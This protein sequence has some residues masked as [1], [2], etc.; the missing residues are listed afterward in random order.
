M[1]KLIHTLLFISFIGCMQAQKIYW[2]DEV[3]SF[4]SE[5]NNN[6]EGEHSYSAQQIL[7]VPNAIGPRNLNH[8]AW[9][10]KKDNGGSEFIH[11]RFNNAVKGVRQIYI[12]E[13]LNPGAISKIIFFDTKG[14]KH[15]VYENKKPQSLG[16]GQPYRM[17]RTQVPPTSYYVK[18]CKVELD[19]RITPSK[20]QLDAI[21]ITDHYGE[22]KIK[23]LIDQIQYARPVPNPENLGRQ[24]NSNYAERLPI[25]SPDGN[26]LYFTRKHHPDNL[27]NAE[28]E[29]DDIWVS[30]RMPNNQWSYA[31]NIGPPLNDEDH[32]FVVSVNPAGN[33][34][35]LGNDYRGK[36]KDAISI[37]SG[38]DGRW[39][40]PEKMNITDHY[41]DNKY[42]E[43]HVSVDEKILL[44]AVERN[45]GYG[46]RDI[47]V[48]FKRGNS[49]TK[50]RNL[51][52]TINTN[53]I[54]SS[55][56]LAADGKTL[57]FA[58]NGHYT[59][60][61]LDV[62]MSRRLDDSWT[63]W[64][65][66]KN[67]GP[68]INSEDD[69]FN[70]TIPA[71]GEYAYFSSSDNSYGMSDLFR[72][73]LPEEARPEPV[74]LMTGQIIDVTTNQP[75]QAKLKY[76]P[77]TK[78]K[79]TTPQAKDD[80]ENE[81]EED[82]SEAKDDGSYQVILP[83]GENVQ[84]YADI[85]GYF[86]VSESMELADEDLEE[87]D[88]DNPDDPLLVFNE[89]P[90]SAEEKAL[91]NELDRLEKELEALKKKKA[92]KKKND[93]T[94]AY[95]YD[96][97]QGIKTKASKP[98]PKAK[99]GKDS[100]LEYLKKKYYDKI[101]GSKDTPSEET[102]PTRTSQKPTSTPPRNKADKNDKEVN[103]MYE[104]LYGKKDKEPEESPSDEKPAEEIITAVEDKPEPDRPTSQPNKNDKEVNSL[105]EKL[106][107][108]KKDDDEVTP[109]EP[110]PGEEPTTE[111]VE[112]VKEEQPVRDPF[113]VPPTE[114]ETPVEDEPV[115]EDITSNTPPEEQM[116][117]EEMEAKVR[118]E[119]KAELLAQIKAEL[120]QELMDEIKTELK[121]ENEEKALIEEAAL[122]LERENR[123]NL[124]SIPSL[125]AEVEGDE[126]EEEL[127]ALIV[128][129]L[130]EE[131]K[132]ELEAPIK[133]ELKDEVS[134]L[135]KEKEK[136]KLSDQ[137]AE[138]KKDRI[139]SG[140]GPRLKDDGPKEPEYVELNQNI[141][142]VPIK[143]GQVI[144][145]NNIFFDA[146]KSDL[147]DES[148][149][150]LERV[151][152]F[153]KKN[154]N[155]V[156]EVGGHTNGWC[157]SSFADQLSRGRSKRV[158]NYFI[159]NGISEN[160]VRYRGYGKT[161]PIAD[162]NTLAGRKKN[163]RVELKI[164]EILD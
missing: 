164:L 95:N 161:M 31:V 112:E 46:D 152:E 90:P 151:L 78:K 52:N 80:D 48:S 126:I 150:E 119:L 142:V 120:R 123:L 3:V 16:F 9:A 111:I 132:D 72:I 128:A 62:F 59:F 56:F 37:S 96:N 130:K 85:E 8:W 50:P 84:V 106:Y 154:N 94:T 18:E 49:W 17:F 29:K 41:N 145:M 19:T 139:N 28:K 118:A 107:G 81:V 155:L 83:Y 122:K 22:I 109:D 104:K 20:N 14:K 87:L 141:Q 103:D 79:K 58:S 131:M 73:L 61:G 135:A 12:S 54:E 21:G 114:E 51:G 68:K 158:M 117:F 159:K 15:V 42:V 45:E 57:Y 115:Q 144:P 13:N 23:G 6:Y 113:Y 156:V 127:R 77:L 26:T 125:K 67:L 157:S 70:Y 116:S 100:E 105:Y 162:N 55:I 11:V 34:I 39:K 137:A 40:R 124:E 140:D 65:A 76:K 138:L 82:V 99:V 121:K 27:G 69:D 24:I 102:Q 75:I 88:S 129:D 7:G 66:P 97:P 147:K 153:L 89:A 25:I 1:Y 38:G 133:E 43:Y 10:P 98:K 108:K 44:M 101:Y 74:M 149:A 63:K 35:Y 4:S 5:Y 47:Y 33:H 53:C 71:S 60:G 36:D 146:N 134:L 143:V 86:P 64:S 110:E 92:D 2:A 136:E 32:N 30:Q 160:K 93:Y 148:F 91:E 163:Q